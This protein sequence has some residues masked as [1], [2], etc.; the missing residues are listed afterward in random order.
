MAETLNKV[1]YIYGTDKNEAVT[2]LA[3]VSEKGFKELEEIIKQLLE[4]LENITLK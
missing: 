3:R 4:K 2:L 1:S